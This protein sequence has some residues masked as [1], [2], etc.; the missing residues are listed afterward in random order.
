MECLQQ[1]GNVWS[2]YSESRV[3]IGSPSRT[4]YYWA[5]KIIAA[6]LKKESH[7]HEGQSVLQQLVDLHARPANYFT[8]F[9]GAALP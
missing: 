1:D 7:G 2:Y 8:E 4:Q 9:L 3:A 6:R 5:A